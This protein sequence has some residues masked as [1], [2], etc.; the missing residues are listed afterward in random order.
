MRL[1]FVLLL[2]YL[3]CLLRP[4]STP[5]HFTSLHFIRASAGASVELRIKHIREAETPSSNA[6]KYLVAVGKHSIALR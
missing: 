5:L 1:L 4:H 6:T 2:F 3:F